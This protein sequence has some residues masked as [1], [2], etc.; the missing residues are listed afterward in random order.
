METSTDHGLTVSYDEE[1][2]IISFDW[3]PVTHPEYNYLEELTEDDFSKML[4]DYL[5][6]YTKQK[7]KEQSTATEI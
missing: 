5:T 4:Q 6:N 2:G 1:A 7:E 3:D